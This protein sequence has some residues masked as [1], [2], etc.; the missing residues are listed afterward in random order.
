MVAHS[1]AGAATHRLG[2]ESIRSGREASMTG[3]ERPEIDAKTQW[4]GLHRPESRAGDQTLL[5]FGE[6]AGGKAVAV[7]IRKT[8]SL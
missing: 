2:D 3:I 5:A 6:V 7:E 8:L 4:R 1:G